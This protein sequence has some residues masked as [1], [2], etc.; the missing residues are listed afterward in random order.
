MIITDGWGIPFMMQAWWLFC[1]CTAI[2]WLVS[3][4]TPA[5][6]KEQIKELVW[7][8]PSAIIKGKITGVA[9]PRLVAGYLLI[10]LVFFYW[11]FA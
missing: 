8:N 3:F 4:A 1:I 6:D 9:D 11:Y 5:P 2:Y 7:G 10:I